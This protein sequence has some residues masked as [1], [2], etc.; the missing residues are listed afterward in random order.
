M[1]IVCTMI[2]VAAALVAG[3]LLGRSNL[4]S[5]KQL[6]GSDPHPPS[7]DGSIDQRKLK[8][9]RRMLDGIPDAALILDSYD[10][11]EGA[12]AIAR[13]LF[14][15][16]DSLSIARTFRS[17]EL[18]EAIDE[19]RSSGR[20]QTCE[21]RMLAPIE[22]R[23]IGTVTPFNEAGGNLQAELLIVLHDVTNQ[24]QLAQMRADFVANASHEL[25]TPLASLKGF[26]TTL[27][28]AAKN[29]DAAR[30]KFLSIM[31]EQANRMS[32]LIDDLLSLSHIEMREHVRP[33]E[34][35]DVTAIAHECVQSLEPI[36]EA[37]SI[38]LRFSEPEGPTAVVGDR[39]ELL[40]AVQNLV[41]NAIKYGKSGGRVDVAVLARGGKV[42]L[43]V[44]DDGIGIAPDHVPRLTERFYRVSA[45]QSRQRGGTG[46]G[47]AIV[48]HIVNRH[49]G[50][51][52]IVSTV[53][54]GST[55]TITLPVV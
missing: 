13:D 47:L 34:I 24:Y 51:L 10:R 7:A 43:S 45:N 31:D 36:A 46:L 9:L 19:A 41:Q 18:L 11:V 35:I 3:V 17:P 42:V 55:F 52:T 23:L 44:T 48:K 49:Q 25:R 26:I 38:T 39:D 5:K 1:E 53:D 14:A 6:T 32:R 37:A 40:Q 12:N 50:E 29:D 21:A 8:I 2:A 22:R 33:R 30:E 20:V 54:R 15:V 4:V 28:G 16:G 27:Q